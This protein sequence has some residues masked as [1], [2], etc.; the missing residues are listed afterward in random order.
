MWPFGMTAEQLERMT[1]EM[2]E[3]ASCSVN[4]AVWKIVNTSMQKWEAEG[5][6]PSQYCYLA[7]A[8]F[9]EFEGKDKG[10]MMAKYQE[11]DRKEMEK[12]YES[13]THSR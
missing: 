8:N 4:D 10:E 3:K 7:M 6:I 1:G 11:E 2:R 5:T 13:L 12:R 9:L